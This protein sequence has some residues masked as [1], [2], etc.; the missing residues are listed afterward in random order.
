MRR[1]SGRWR[2]DERRAPG[3]R[4]KRGGARPETGEINRGMADSTPNG[5]EPEII[6]FCCEH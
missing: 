6:A 1:R 4:D 2:R 3:R 5:F